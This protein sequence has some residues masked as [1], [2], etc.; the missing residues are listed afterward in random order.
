MRRVIVPLLLILL[1]AVEHRAH[2]QIVDVQSFI[3]HDIP[4]GVSGKLDASVDWRTG[5]TRLLH[6]AAALGARWRVHEHLLFALARGEY[7]ESAGFGA[8]L[9]TDA[10][11]DFEHVRYRWHF[12]PWIATE[13]FAQHES[14]RFKRL[15]LRAL[16]GAGLRVRV[17]ECGTTWGIHVGAAYMAEY[18]QLVDD[19]LPDA[20]D[21]AA[22]SRL[23]T[24]AV[25]FWKL[26]PDV[27]ASETVYA[28]PRFADV[29][30]VRL[31]EEA[32][33]TA[34][35]VS[36]VDFKFALVIARDSRPPPDTAKTDTSLQSGV[37]VTF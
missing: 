18:E 35:L 2:A 7:G 4:E 23:S 6:A 15:R 25:A 30:D 11:K 31:L 27:T 10:K 37:Q 29:R 17:A 34:K 12:R 9:V 20:G 5:N 19:A 36:H 32:A 28:Q 1:A 16:V 24:Y 22:D 8:P 21:T 3:G 33:I 14:D 26:N 13:V